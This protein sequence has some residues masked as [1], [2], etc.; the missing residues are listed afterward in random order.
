[1][2]PFTFEKLAEQM[3]I[4]DSQT[5]QTSGLLNFINPN[6]GKFK[7]CDSKNFRSVVPAC[8]NPST[9]SQS[10]GDVAKNLSYQSQLEDPEFD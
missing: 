8:R 5:D 7:A 6:K 10:M 9:S 2:K 4:E 3:N 1:M